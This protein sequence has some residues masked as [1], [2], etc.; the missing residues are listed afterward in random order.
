MRRHPVEQHAEAGRAAG[1]HEARE[2]VGRTEARGRRVHA[3]R[4]VAPGSVERM[5]GDRQQLDVRE[6]ELG[7]IGRQRR[8]QIVPAVETAVGMAPPRA[9]VD[10]VDRD[11]AHGDRWRRRGH[12]AAAAPAAARRRCSRWPAAS[13][14]RAHRDRPSTATARRS[15][16]PVRTCRHRR[17]AAC[18]M[19][20]SQMPLPWRD[21]ITWRRPSHELK[22]PTTLTRRAFGAQTAKRTPSTSPIRIGSAPRL[23]NGRR[24][25]PSPR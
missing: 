14:P 22:L 8:G 15:G 5:F 1:R 6:A 4:L 13:R 11:R 10:L 23:S 20:I 3:Q 25:E 9:E 17:S 12:R 19:K 2:T 24:C 21:R 16:R 7:D 18:G